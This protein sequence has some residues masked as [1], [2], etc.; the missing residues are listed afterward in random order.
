MSSI[1]TSKYRTDDAQLFLDNVNSNDYYL[2][3]STLDR[4]DVNNSE[5]YKNDFLEKTIFGKKIKSSDMF[6]MINNNRW[7]E[8]TV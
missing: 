4:Y 7:Q 2:F 3:V 5:Y 1:V 6:Y 8:N